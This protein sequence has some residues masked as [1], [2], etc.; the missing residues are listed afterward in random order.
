M[1]FKLMSR[2]MSVYGVKNQ[3][4]K[5]KKQGTESIRT[6][7]FSKILSR[8]SVLA[9]HPIIFWTTSE[10]WESTLVFEVS[11]QREFATAYLEQTKQL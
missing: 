9:T 5:T 8:F 4:Q 10:H 11:K 2:L 3:E 1:L 6:L 7:N